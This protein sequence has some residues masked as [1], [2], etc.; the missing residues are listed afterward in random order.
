VPPPIGI[1]NPPVITPGACYQIVPSYNSLVPVGP[2]QEY[3][4][5]VPG[6]NL[7][8]DYID[9]AIQFMGIDWVTVLSLFVSISC[10]FLIYR[11]I[12]S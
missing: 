8:I 1:I 6:V 7:C 5:T 2:G 11:E 3:N 4:F 10:I 9:M 12:H